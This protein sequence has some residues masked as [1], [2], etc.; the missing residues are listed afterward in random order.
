[1]SSGKKEQVKFRLHP[2]NKNRDRYDLPALLKVNS[3][4]K[5]CVQPNKFG[6]ASIDF[7]NPL[8]VKLLN[9]AILHHYYGITYWEFPEKNLCPPIPGRADYVHYLADLLAEG[10]RGKIPT[11]DN[12]KG[13]DIGVGA[14]C[15]YP[16]L[17]VTEYGWSFI[18]T[19]IDRASLASSNKIVTS[20]P[21]LAG[22]IDCRLQK[23]SQFMLKAY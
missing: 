2:R 17:G 20:N 10:N 18:G 4:L 19:D 9:K 12:I 5:K 7:A 8:S 22:K 21:T 14:S 16:I 1:M 15:I 6:E 3:A 23:N 13:I 11:G